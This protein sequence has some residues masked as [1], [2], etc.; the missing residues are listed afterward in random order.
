MTIAKIENI[1]SPEQLKIINDA[2][3]QNE[4]EIHSDL[5]RKYMGTIRE[6][7]PKDI[8]DKLYDIATQYL[9]FAPSISHIMAVEYSA[10]YGQPN[11]P[12]HF[13]G[14]TNELI[15]NMQLEA[16]TSWDLGLNLQTYSLEDNSAL[17]FNGNTEI[18]WRTHKEF[19]PGEYVRMMFV[20]FCNEKN[21]SDYSH[22]P[23]NHIDDTF[24]ATRKFRDSLI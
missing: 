21:M 10:E 11:L 23:M 12:P 3:S 17:V 22:L 18:H 8:L 6:I 15:I 4:T 16:N 14:D 13:D 2:F 20:R 9:D 24:K 1:F 7:L 19:K 5:G